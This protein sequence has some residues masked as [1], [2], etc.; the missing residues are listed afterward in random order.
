MPVSHNRIRVT[1]VPDGRWRTRAGAGGRCGSR[2]QLGR[3]RC[4]SGSPF[5][6][7]S[8]FDEV[9]EECV[10]RVGPFGGAVTV[11]VD[12]V[13]VPV[14]Q[15]FRQHVGY[16]SGGNEY[17]VHAGMGRLAAGFV[18]GGAF[19]FGHVEESVEF[20]AAFVYACGGEDSA[21]GPHAYCLG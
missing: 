3:W 12:A 19:S 17:R 2:Q 9:V 14:R 1:V 7:G 18:S 16:F 10:Q 4:A 13:K 20:A 6:V 11:A 5:E 8:L 21:V 15:R